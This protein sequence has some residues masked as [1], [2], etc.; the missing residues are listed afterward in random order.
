MINDRKSN[1]SNLQFHHYRERK[2][3]KAGRR[4]QSERDQKSIEI[5]RRISS[6]N[7]GVANEPTRNVS[8]LSW[9][10]RRTLELSHMV[11]LKNKYSHEL[12]WWTT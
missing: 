7:T 12:F 3:Y 10:H 9:D 2:N 11:K 8:T 1:G 4:D 6:T 5:S